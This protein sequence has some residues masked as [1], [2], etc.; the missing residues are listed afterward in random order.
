MGLRFKMLIGYSILITLLVFIVYLFRQE[1]IKRSVLQKDE[2]EMVYTHKLVE[3]TYM[4]LWELTTQAE[5]VS[6]WKENDL[7]CY[8]VKRREICDT[9]QVLRDYVHTPE[10]EK[11][12]DSLCSL[13]QEK[14]CL[15]SAVMNTFLQLQEVGNSVR[16]K[17]PIIVSQIKH[18]SQKNDTVPDI[19]S[20]DDPKTEKGFWS[21]FHRKKSKSAY[22][23]QRER[24]ARK[25]GYQSS[26]F[27]HKATLFIG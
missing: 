4:Q 17:I 6:V 18:I 23:K 5:L 19:Q 24:N 1:Q 25:K 15:L 7:E 8:R 11:Q 3:R 27:F 2:R 10:Q 26:I 9:L 13:L 22:L 12:I 21:I 14:E 20:S 16:K